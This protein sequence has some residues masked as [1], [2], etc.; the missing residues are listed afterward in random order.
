MKK[1]RTFS[2]YSEVQREFIERVKRDGITPTH[3]WLSKMRGERDFSFSEPIRLT[4]GDGE[5]LGLVRISEREDFS[6]GIFRECEE[7]E[8][9]FKNYKVGT[10]YFWSAK[11]ITDSF[12]TEDERFRFIHAEG[13]KNIRDLGGGKIKQ[14]LIYRGSELLGHYKLTEEGIRVLRDELK[15][16]T[17]L[18]MRGECLGNFTDS[19]LCESVRFLQI[20]YRP[21]DEAFEEVH[22]RSLAKIFDLLADENSYPLYFHCMGGADR[23]GMIALYLEALCDEDEET[24]FLDYEL[25]SLSTIP[26]LDSESVAPVRSREFD[27]FVDFMERL[28]AYCEG[29]SLRDKVIGYLHSCGI[30]DETIGKI[31]EILKK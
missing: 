11:G 27:Y 16:K 9:L 25:T 28:S 18:D 31:I 24:I 1:E 22:K 30:T 10:R 15:I 14:G 13:A 26:K 19:V 3:K 20:P 29:G 8:F 4:L 21:Y 12:L 7:S 23:T 5:P 6:E 17:E 2:V